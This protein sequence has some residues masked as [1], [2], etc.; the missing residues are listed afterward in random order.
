MSDLARRDLEFFKSSIHGE[1]GSK[2]SKCKVQ[3]IA[4]SEVQDDQC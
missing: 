1:K 4:L 3:L 2:D